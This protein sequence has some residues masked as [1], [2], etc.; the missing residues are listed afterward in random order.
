LTGDSGIHTVV[1]LRSD[2]PNYNG[3][4]PTKPGSDWNWK[5][6]VG[7]GEHTDDPA[8]GRNLLSNINNFV[9]QTNLWDRN[10]R[11]TL[12]PA[13]DPTDADGSKPLSAFLSDE[14]CVYIMK[15]MYGLTS[16]AA[17]LQYDD[18]LADFFGSAEAGRAVINEMDDAEF[19][20]LA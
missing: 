15:V 1:E 9:R 4:K 11:F 18:M 8:F 6:L 10:P 17:I 14:D 12:R 5:V 20:M 3:K 13:S 16:K 2:D 19:D 7:V